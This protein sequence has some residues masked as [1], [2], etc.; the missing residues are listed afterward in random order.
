MVVERYTQTRVGF[1]DHLLTPRG[2]VVF[3]LLWAGLF[4]TMVLIVTPGASSQDAQE[5]EILQGQLAAGY[6]LDPRL[7]VCFANPIG[8]LPR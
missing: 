5:A 1:W 4:V 2:I 6:Q 7:S 8:K 3:W